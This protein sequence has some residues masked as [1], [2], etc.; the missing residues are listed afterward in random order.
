VLASRFVYYFP[1][2]PYVCSLLSGDEDTDEEGDDD[3]FAEGA[4]DVSYAGLGT[5]QSCRS[6]CM[7]P[8]DLAHILLHVG[9]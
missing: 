6:I 2:A 1:N 9:Q 3:D 5:M 7:S 4:D 8:S